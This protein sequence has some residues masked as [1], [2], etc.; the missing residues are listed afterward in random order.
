MCCQHESVNYGEGY[1]AL[2]HQQH[3]I[4][5]TDGVGAFFLS[6]RCRCSEDLTSAIPSIYVR[7]T[8]KQ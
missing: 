2:V 3:H 7:G 5:Q 8:Y 4:V 6:L 1:S